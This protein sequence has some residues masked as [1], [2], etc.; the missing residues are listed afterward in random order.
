MVCSFLASAAVYETFQEKRG[1]KRERKRK[2][3]RLQSRREA[4]ILKRVDTVRWAT[5][6]RSNWYREGEKSAYIV[7]E[8]LDGIRT[9]LL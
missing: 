1:Y 5:R 9:E 7:I 2:C 4:T 8:S 3:T 6:N